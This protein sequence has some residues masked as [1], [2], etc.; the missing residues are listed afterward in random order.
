[1]ASSP[2]WQKIY[3][4]LTSPRCI[5]CHTITNYPR[6]GDDRHPHIFGIVRGVDDKGAPVAR[7]TACHGDQNNAATGIPGRSDWHVAPLANA[8]ET[9]PGVIMTPAELCAQMKDLTRNGNRNMAQL[10]E[11]VE[12]E[13]FVLWAWDPGT[14]WNAEA[15]QTPPLSHE[16]FAKAFKGWADAGAACPGATAETIQTGSKR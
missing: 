7:C 8:W 2:Q 16:E 11:H 9:A 15:R 3:S 13:H 14:R 4:V 5:N 1:M 10:I 6:Q 12:T